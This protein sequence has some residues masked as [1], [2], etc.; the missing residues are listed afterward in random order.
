MSEETQVLAEV[1]GN[2]PN[3][4]HW[5]I[6]S[7][8]WEG[9]K[10]FLGDYLIQH[11]NKW[12]VNIDDSNRLFLSQCIRNN[13][14]AEASVHMTLDSK[15]GVTL[16]RSYDKMAGIGIEKEFYKSL[17]L[18]SLSDDIEIWLD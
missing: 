16:F 14:L 9:F 4:S 7:D 12:F 17:S 10:P 13:D 5:Y 8:S 2:A 11:H 1:I 18:G 6:S 15:E 3:G